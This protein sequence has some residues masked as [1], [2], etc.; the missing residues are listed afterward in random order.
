MELFKDQR[1]L[2]AEYEGF[3]TPICEY[4][5]ASR[6]DQPELQV[7]ALE[8]EEGRSKLKC[9]I[10]DETKQKVEA[11]SSEAGLQKLWPQLTGR[12]RIS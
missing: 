6:I 12:L 7:E 2:V 9:T 4:A 11:V 3:T 5:Y 10:I 1:R 8:A